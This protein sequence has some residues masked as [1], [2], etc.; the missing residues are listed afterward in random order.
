[1]HATELP[2][3]IIHDLVTSLCSD[4]LGSGM[5]R[6]VYGFTIDPNL[7]LKLEIGRSHQNAIE[8]ETWRALKDTKHAQWLAPCRWLSDCGTALLMERT[9]PMRPGEEPTGLPKWLTDF[10]RSNYGKLGDKIV[11]HDYGTNLL[12][13]H[14]AFAS[15]ALHKPDWWD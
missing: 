9:Q 10:K 14:G 6:Q 11:C 13:N 3:S 5:S 1:M 8:W 2:I 4:S 12:L 15:K 7:V